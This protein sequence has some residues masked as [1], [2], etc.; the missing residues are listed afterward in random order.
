[1]S[2]HI[3]IHIHRAGDAGFSE[4]DH[5]RDDIGKFGSGG[6]KKKSSGK[7]VKGHEIEF[8][9]GKKMKIKAFNDKE[10]EA[11]AKKAGLWKNGGD[12]PAFTVRK[13][14][15]EIGGG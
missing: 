2:R 12:F 10:I 5:P 4:N 11:A 3:H 15:E 13:D 6:G 8:A 7:A 9:N 14:G 1:M